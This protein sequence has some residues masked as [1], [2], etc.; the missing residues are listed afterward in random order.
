M[1]AY[2]GYIPVVQSR[3]MAEGY[4]SNSKLQQLMASGLFDVAT[5]ESVIDKGGD[6]AQVPLK[7]QADDFTHVVLASDETLTT[8]PTRITTN[9]SKY[10][11]LWDAS[12]KGLTEI[13]RIR[14]N[15]DWIADLSMS[16]GNK[17][18]KRTIKQLDRVLKACLT[19]QSAHIKDITAATTKTVNVEALLDTKTLL[20]DQSQDLSIMLVHSKAINNLYKQLGAGSGYASNA[21]VAGEMIRNGALNTILGVGTIVVSDDLT[22]DYGSGSSAGTDTYWTYMFRPGA[23]Y[24]AYQEA[25]IFHEFVDSRS[26]STLITLT[27]RM[28][29]VVGPH[30][31]AWG[32]TGNPTDSDLGTS[33]N[34]SVTTEDHRN[35]GV[36]ALRSYVS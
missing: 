25:P 26:P 33:G 28:G 3:Y 18:A 35:I 13:D 30:G 27:W 16:A 24:H 34:W 12:Q 15:E 5:L 11:V 19:A 7:V 14:T 36:V 2:S 20:G 23:V 21:V 10:P 8:S 4:F 17:A 29:Y 32:S 31:F 1:A 9:N 22:K 6:Y